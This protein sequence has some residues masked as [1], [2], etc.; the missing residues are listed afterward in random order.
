M[1]ITCCKV[2]LP[3]H[4]DKLLNNLIFLKMVLFSPKNF[5][6]A[7]KHHTIIDCLFICTF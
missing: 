7:P 5:P 2:Q 3:R 4:F 6:T 1:F